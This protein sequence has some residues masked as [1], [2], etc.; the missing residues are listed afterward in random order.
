[1]APPPRRTTPHSGLLLSP[2]TTVSD[3]LPRFCTSCWRLQLAAMATPCGAGTALGD[4]ALPLIELASDLPPF[5]MCLVPPPRASLIQLRL[6]PLVGVHM[7]PHRTW[8]QTSLGHWYRPRLLAR[9]NLPR[10]GLVK[11]RL[12]PSLLMISRGPR[13]LIHQPSILRILRLASTPVPLHL[14]PLLP[15]MDSLLLWSDP[16]VE[17]RSTPALSLASALVLPP[18]Q[19]PPHPLVVSRLLLLL[20]L[21]W[22]ILALSLA[23]F[24]P[25]PLLGAAQALSPLSCP[26]ALSPLL[27]PSPPFLLPLPLLLASPCLC[28]ITRQRH[29]R[30]ALSVK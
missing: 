24:L 20:D 19:Q 2:W 21:E 26:R 30:S 23:P 11:T 14:Q 29:F 12:D 8:T 22:S 25:P 1:M 27:P 28:P 7:P 4:L 17:A 9:C 5:H 18:P 6:S 13:I 3:A 16:S 15:L 10:S